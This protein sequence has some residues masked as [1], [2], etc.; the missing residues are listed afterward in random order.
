MEY[1]RYKPDWD[2]ILIQELRYKEFR[3]RVDS[4]VGE[5]NTSLCNLLPI[6]NR[7]LPHPRLLHFH[8]TMLGALKTNKTKPI[9]I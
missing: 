6:H 8:I 7:I 1:R 2:C 9:F 5:S 4:D 3:Q